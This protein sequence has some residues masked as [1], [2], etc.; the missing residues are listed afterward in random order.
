MKYVKTFED[1]EVSERYDYRYMQRLR[2]LP[3]TIKKS[4]EWVDP[5]IAYS[6]FISAIDNEEDSKKSAEDLGITEIYRVVNISNIEYTI[7]THDE[8]SVSS[9]LSHSLDIHFHNQ[10]NMILVGKGYLITLY[11]RDVST[12]YV[13]TTKYK[14]PVAP[15]NKQT[16]YDE[17]LVIGKDVSW[18]TL[19]FNGK[20]TNKNEYESLKKISEK[21]KFVLVDY[22][23]NTKELPELIRNSIK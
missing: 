9:K 21:L 11:D 17:G 3:I 2:Q 14:T 23:A 22:S 10:E 4:P 12:N 20:T 1:F 6:D 8:I 5:N 7:T 18:K 19:Y 13:G 15:Y 16:T